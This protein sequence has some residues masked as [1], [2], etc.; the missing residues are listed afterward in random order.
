MRTSIKFRNFHVKKLYFKNYF[1]CDI[2]NYWGL[3]FTQ[4]GLVK[5]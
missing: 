1:F 5:K 2:K 4:V 3:K